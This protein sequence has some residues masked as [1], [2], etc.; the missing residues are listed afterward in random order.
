MSPKTRPNSSLTSMPSIRW[1]TRRRLAAL[2]AALALPLTAATATYASPSPSS[3]AAQHQA[4]FTTGSGSFVMA[5]GNG[6][7]GATRRL[8]G[9]RRS[10]TPSGTTGG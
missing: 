10:G 5:L 9:I 1:I 4:Q 7:G 8:K 3:G 6:T 2:A